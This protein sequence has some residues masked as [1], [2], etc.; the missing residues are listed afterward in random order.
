MKRVRVRPLVRL[1][2]LGVLLALLA[3]GA[4]RLARGLAQSEVA[5]AIQQ[6]QHLAHRPTVQLRGFPFLTQAAGGHFQGGR[7]IVT[8]FPSPKVRIKTVRIDLT[9]VTL[10]PGDLVSGSVRSV[11]VARIDGLALITYLDLA[12]ATDVEGLQIRPD[13]GRLELRLPLRYLGQ[14]VSLVITGRVTLQGKSVRIA[15]G[16]LRGLPLPPQVDQAAIARLPS[17][18]PLDTLP[19]GLTVTGIRVADSG[20]EVR[21]HARNVVLRRH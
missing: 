14:T 17:T 20:L 1:V 7:V 8:D 18:I 5:T 15:W 4:D 21:V 9:G 10:S 6:Q 16:P 12:L 11:P 13:N 3:V 2:V 19:Y